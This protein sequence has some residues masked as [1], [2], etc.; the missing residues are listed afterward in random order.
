MNLGVP[1]N[2][3]A[4][5][6][7][8]PIGRWAPI[9]MWSLTAAGVLGPAWM[10]PSNVLACEWLLLWAVFISAC[11]LRSLAR[12]AV[13]VRHRLPPETLRVDDAFRFRTHRAFAVVT[14][15]VLTRAPFLLAL[16]FSRPWLDH[17]A[18]YFWAVLPADV[19]PQ[20]WPRW[21]GLLL[22][23][24]IEAT[25]THVTF[26]LFGGGDVTYYQTADGKGLRCTWNTWQEYF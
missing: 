3:V 10:A 18:H 11:W 26:H 24:R 22:V 23:R 14:M 9:A 19:E 7:L 8:R 17:Q 13:V 6:L 15:L 5:S 16:F 2:R 1:V 25:P 4:L 12:R 21:Q 20:Q